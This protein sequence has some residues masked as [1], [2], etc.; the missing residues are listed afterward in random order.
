MWDYLI[1][2]YIVASIINVAYVFLCS[3]QVA[4]EY[5]KKRPHTEINSIKTVMYLLCFVPIINITVFYYAIKTFVTGACKSIF[6]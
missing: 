3:D 1:L 2:I 6:K 5:R 4:V